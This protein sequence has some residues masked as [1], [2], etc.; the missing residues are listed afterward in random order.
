[1]G[2]SAIEHFGERVLPGKYGFR[3]RREVYALPSKQSSFYFGREMFSEE[4]WTDRAASYEDEAQRIYKDDVV[5]W[6][7]ERALFNFDLNL[8]F[9]DQVPQETFDHAVAAMLKGAPAL[10]PVTHLPSLDGMRGLY[11]L[12]LDDYRQAYVGQASD[13][14]GRVRQHWR[15][16]KQ[17]DRLV[18]GHAH[19]SVLSID[20]FRALD[21]TRIFAAKTS[22]PDALERRV[23]REFP[24]DLLLNRVGGGK[25]DA[26]RMTYLGVEGKRRQLVAE[27]RGAQPQA[28]NEAHGGGTR[29]DGAA[30]GV[31]ST[32]EV[33]AA[34]SERWGS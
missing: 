16:M 21:T 23:V 33:E 17:L 31:P 28:P 13:I 30:T 2:S 1:M 6:M 20:V 5:E 25:P 34:S 12:V 32:T 11:V 19:A 7:R 14:R 18:F 4:A 24:G 27:A 26:H 22:R 9:F 15:G 29:R 10:H 3:L 8:A